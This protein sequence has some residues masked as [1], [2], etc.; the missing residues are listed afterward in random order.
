MST[1]LPPLRARIDRTRFLLHHTAEQVQRALELRHLPHGTVLDPIFISPESDRIDRYTRGGDSAIWSGHYL[2]AQ[3][4][5]YV[6]T[7]APDAFEAVRSTIRS[8]R[9]LIEV[10]GTNLLARVWLP[11][12]SPWVD[13]IVREERHHRIYESTVDGKPAVWIGN[14]SRDQYMGFFFGLSVAYEW[15]TDAG[16]RGEIAHIVTRA[17]DFLLEKGWAVVMP[18]GES[19]TVFWQRVDQRLA[20][21]QVGRQVNDAHF[22]SL[23]RNERFLGSLAVAT[24]VAFEIAEPHD[25]YFKLNL[26]AIGMFCLIRGELS[27]T[28]RERYL[29]AYRLFR[30]TVDDHGNAHFDMIDRALE[31]PNQAR[32]LRLTRLLEAW[33]RRPRRDYYVDLR[34][35]VASCGEDRACEAIP[36]EKRVN[37]DFLWQRSPFLLYGGGDGF[38]ETAGIDFLLPYWMGRV[39][40][41]L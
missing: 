25:S 3:T 29:D 34:G 35:E 21:L 27:D 24:P 10:T 12:D 20:L 37:T 39:Y 15:I 9:R 26:V 38:I 13:A 5:R 4:Y 32:D 7:G 14:T 31:G 40:G 28:H 2:A 22:S 11:A 16:V 41:V 33:A 19:S 23:Y 30:K 18:N 6:A 8:M 1:F 17:L 36:I